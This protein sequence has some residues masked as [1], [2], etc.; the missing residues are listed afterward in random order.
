M[1]VPGTEKKDPYR[2]LAE[3]NR[4]IT[5]SLNFEEVLEL[6]VENATQ[7]VDARIAALLLVDKDG[8]L[9]IR[10]ARGLDA[11][12]VNSFSGHM[13][14][15]VIDQLHK[16]LG[17]PVEETL[18]AV[19]VIAKNSLNGLLIIVRGRPFNEEEGWQVSAL[20]DQ[21]AIALRNARL[22]EIE[23]AEASRERDETLEALKES[24]DRINRILSSMTDVFYS[25]DRDWRFTDINTQAE[26][27]F[28]KSREELIGKVLWEVYPQ[29]KRS[30]LFA[31]FSRALEEMVPVNFEVE[32]QLV[33]GVWFE[34]HVYPSRKGLSVYLRDVSERKLAEAATRRLASI[35]ETSDD[36]IISKDLKGII[37]SWNRG[38]RIIFGYTAE[39]VI[40]KSV[41]ILIPE[42]RYDEEP[43]I[44]GKIAKGIPIQ[45]YETVR[46]RKDGSYVDISLT[47]SPLRNERDEI[48]GAS[49]IARDISLRKLAESEREKMFKNAQEA[50]A[51]A[52]K[53][54][55]LKDEFLATL[56]HELRNP[57][58]VIL[59]YSEVLL[60][61]DEV[62][63]SA[64]LKRAVE[65]LRRNA[66]AQAQLVSDL[67]DL[68][69]LHTGKLSLN[70]ETVSLASAVHNS[71]ETVRIDAAAKNIEIS[72]NTSNEILFV[73]ADPLRLEQVVWNLLTNA[74]KFTPAG[75]KVSV[76][77]ARTD[78]E[79]LLIV[80]D[81]GQ[82]IDPA[83]A[84]HLFEM[85]RQADGSSS[86]RHG[87]MGIG[88]ALVQQLVKLHNGSV[89]MES[90][91]LGQ[92]SK[93]TV[94]LP[95]SSERAAQSDPHSKMTTGALNQMRILVVDDSEDNVEML[96]RLFEMDG[97]KVSTAAG[98]SE[99]LEIIRDNDF[100]VILTDISMPEMD[101]FEFLR[102][103]RE[104]PLKRDVPVLAL[105]GFGRAEDV[106]RA[107][108][109]GF[110]S[111]VTKPIDINKLVALLRTIPVSERSYN[112][113]GRP[114]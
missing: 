30:K 80:Q 15:D 45:H 32:S 47:V 60:R 7:L 9:R 25:L 79:A 4:A 106:E 84:P 110:F 86:R 64:L 65:V 103:L 98:G 36:A 10:A 33:P 72:V 17:A 68:S 61:N 111:H 51:D 46:R 94:R 42:E 88:L 105:T 78:D 114:I 43:E 23:L 1:V 19:P 87:G 3:I 74:V 113:D 52:E 11:R 85:F 16:L 5:T 54:N 67:L 69:R 44:L 53:A 82:G 41:T 62:Q 22:Y 66:E 8:L 2:R 58:N 77:L 24:N 38:A 18:V 35:V 31:E 57:L 49:K 48:I 101:G 83:F 59:G 56:S 14:E 90:P 97:A 63:K 93:F 102:R 100:E 40:G 81:T 109:E 39:E 55:Q 112:A 95:L 89:D 96:R 91:G 104:M 108:A 12:L 75:G 107:E 76:N 28:G 26:K 37:T 73:D 34:A 13:E 50:R 99:A 27:R 20:A 6:I 21:A 71:V 92:G 29:A 70:R